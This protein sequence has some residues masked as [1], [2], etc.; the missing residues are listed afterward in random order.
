MTHYKIKPEEVQSIYAG[1][2]VACHT[3]NHPVLKDCT[4]EEIV[5]QINEDIHVL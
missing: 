1:H 2:E 5:W 4:D 3:V